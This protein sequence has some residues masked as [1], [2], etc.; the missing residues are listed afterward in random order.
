MSKLYIK[1]FLAYLG[2]IFLVAAIILVIWLKLGIFGKYGNDAINDREQ[3]VSESQNNSNSQNSNSTSEVESTT[4]FITCK[5]SESNGDDYEYD[6]YIDE[7][8]LKYTIITYEVTDKDVIEELM[9]LDDKEYDDEELY[10]YNKIYYYDRDE[11]ID[12]DL[13][14]VNQFTKN[15]SLSYIKRIM[16][17]EGYVCK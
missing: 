7:N 14:L 6:F 9:K 16:S 1:T 15:S 2:I 11:K 12:S 4:N 3:Q 10:F 13:L 8:K 17:N 5:K